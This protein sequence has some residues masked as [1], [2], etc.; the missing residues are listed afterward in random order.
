MA[1]LIMLNIGAMAASLVP[2]AFIKKPTDPMKQTSISIGVG[3]GGSVPHVAIWGED[4]AQISQFK[5]AANGHTHKGETWQTVV[6]DYQNG[7]RPAN[8]TYVSVVI[9]END[10]ICV[11]AISV[12]GNGQQ[13][14]WIADMASFCGAQW[15]ESDYTFQGSNSPMRCAWI[16]AYH[17]N[18]IIA[19]RMSMHIQ[20]FTGDPGC[21]GNV[22]RTQIDCARI[23]EG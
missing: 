14:I 1:T 22:R 13:W 10:A 23:A 3:N 15:M 12:S 18:N 17:T 5:G 7:M 19:K 2:L 4:G 6:G 16:D 20:D 21:C 8:P 9:H 11:A